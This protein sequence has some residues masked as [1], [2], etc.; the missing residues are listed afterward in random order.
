MPRLL[1]D[2]NK[3]CIPSHLLGALHERADPVDVIQLVK[4][5]TEAVQSQAKL[6]SLW[7]LR[8]RQREGEEE[9]N[10]NQNGTFDI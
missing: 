8:L 2:T 3:H 9:F 6:L 4:L 5:S 7:R 10:Y 1:S